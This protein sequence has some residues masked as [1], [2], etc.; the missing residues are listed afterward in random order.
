MHVPIIDR[1]QPDGVR[2]ADP[3][4]Q[5]LVE[6]RL[7]RELERRRLQ[8]LRLDP[9]ARERWLDIVESAAWAVLRPAQL[10]LL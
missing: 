1:L 3:A 4:F 2:A 5:Q 6:E 8:P 7:D 9:A 10:Q